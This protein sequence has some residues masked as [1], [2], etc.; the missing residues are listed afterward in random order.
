MMIFY[1]K[2]DASGFDS[3]GVSSV[4]A[5]DLPAWPLVCLSVASFTRDSLHHPVSQ[6]EGRKGKA[7]QMARPSGLVVHLAWLQISW[8]VA[9]LFIQLFAKVL[10]PFLLERVEGDSKDRYYEEL[11]FLLS[12]LFS[13]I[14]RSP[15]LETRVYL[16]SRE[17]KTENNSSRQTIG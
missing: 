5:A 1:P 9:H 11:S 12:I 8:Q 3:S 4:D 16:V 15:L 10:S 6:K 2:G 17:G 13:W 14:S 7:A